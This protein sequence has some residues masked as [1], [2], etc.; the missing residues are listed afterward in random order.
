MVL[1]LDLVHTVLLVSQPMVKLGKK[2]K[3]AVPCVAQARDSG[4]IGARKK[5]NACFAQK[6]STRR[7]VFA[8]DALLK[9]PVHMVNVG[10]TVWLSARR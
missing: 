4:I 6:I 7:K 9:Y 10:Q 2:A 1:G 3:I 5:K 8:K